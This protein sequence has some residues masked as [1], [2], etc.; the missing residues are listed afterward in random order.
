MKQ[1]TIDHPRYGLLHTVS[2][3]KGINQIKA[4]DSPESALLRL[5]N[6]KGG[7][8]YKSLEDALKY[9]GDTM[10]HCVGGYCPEVAEGRTRIFSLRDAKNEPHVTIEVKPPKKYDE[11][12]VFEQ[13]RGGIHDAMRAG[14]IGAENY[15]AKKLTELN[16]PNNRRQQI[17][18][19]KGKGNAK[20][21]KDYIP[22]VQDFVKSGNWSQINDSQNAGLRRYDHVF[23][24]NEQRA[25]E[26]TG[27]PVPNHEYLTGD[28]IQR[29]HNAIYPKGQ[30]LKY[31]AEGNIVGDERQPKQHAKGG[32][33]DRMRDQLMI[34]GLAE[35][36]QWTFKPGIKKVPEF[37]SPIDQALNTIRQ[38]K[39][40]RDQYLS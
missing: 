17:L 13:F 15:V 28:Q 26:R 20:P 11:W 3:P 1:D 40:T 18:Q 4:T 35:G 2:D 34:K 21:K 30:R 38:P 27:E 10:G 5:Y 29:L 23:N 31:D 19:I 24:D 36:G 37:Y 8:G 9:E 22:Y 14:D 7:E 33:V 25:I 32:N 39:G 16:S 6:S 12:D